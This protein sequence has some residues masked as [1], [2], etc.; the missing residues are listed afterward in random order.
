MY[1]CCECENQDQLLEQTGFVDAKPVLVF[2][3][4]L[5]MHKYE[6]KH[7]CP[8]LFTSDPPKNVDSQS[9]STRVRLSHSWPTI[10]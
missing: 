10:Q 6:M 8:S 5:N 9:E 4:T 1:D 2:H 7:V 3:T